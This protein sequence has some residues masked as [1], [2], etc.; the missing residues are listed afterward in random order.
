MGFFCAART[1]I[2]TSI[3]ISLHYFTVV[4]K[5][6]SWNSSTNSWRLLFWVRWQRR[7]VQGVEWE[8]KG[9]LV[10]DQE[11]DKGQGGVDLGAISIYQI[12]LPLL[13]SFPGCRVPF[14]FLDSSQQCG[15]HKSI[16]HQATSGSVKTI[17]SYFL[18]ALWKPP[19]T[20][21][22]ACALS[23]WL[24]RCQWWEIGLGS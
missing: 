8:G 24:H 10:A 12:L 14:L 22:P 11:K 7:L 2:G 19:P 4:K 6:G 5:Q 16:V 15:W 13:S 1:S 21:D 23:T 17:F 18:L 3:P 20:L 9:S